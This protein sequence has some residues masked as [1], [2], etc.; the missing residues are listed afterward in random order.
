MEPFAAEGVW[1]LPED[2]ERQAAGVL[3]FEPY[4]EARLDL[5]GTLLKDG[6]LVAL[7]TDPM[8]LT[9][10]QRAAVEHA[11]REAVE[12]AQSP[13]EGSE[14][15]VEARADAFPITVATV[16]GVVMGYEMTLHALKE[17]A[18]D[19]SSTPGFSKQSFVIGRVL[20]GA[21]LG[22][23]Q[24]VAYDTANIGLD[25]LDAWCGDV[26]DGVAEGADSQPPPKQGSLGPHHTIKC[27]V[28]DDDELSLGYR[29]GNQ[30]SSHEQRTW[31][32]PE[33]RI[34][35]STTRT[36]QQILSRY[37]RPLQDLLTATSG[38]PSALTRLMVTTADATWDGERSP[39]TSA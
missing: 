6:P 35:F 27:M 17:V 5:I 29:G 11:M 13:E 19:D 18:R 4:G 34:R 7:A 37:V 15:A 28:V 33:F 31:R 22:D 1:W 26:L 8:G 12:A 23:E 25:H 21:L 16:H 24:D 9:D 38:R 14:A 3:Q 2:A 32:E 39:S 10:E 30:I 20:R 36:L